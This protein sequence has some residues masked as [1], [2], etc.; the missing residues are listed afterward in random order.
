MKKKISKAR[1]REQ[2]RLAVVSI[3]LALIVWMI[4]KAGE[5][6]EAKLTIPIEVA[7]PSPQVQV[8]VIP[9]AIPVVVRYG[10]DASPYISSENFKFVVDAST[11]KDNL[12]VSWKTMTMSLSDKNWVANI[13]SAHVDLVKIGLQSSTVEV[14]MR[15]DAVPAIIKPEIVGQDRLPAGYQLVSPVKTT[16]R[17]V[18][19]IGDEDKLQK[20]SID[21]MTSRAVLKTA[22][23]SVA[24]KTESSF[25]SVELLLPPGVSVVQ[26][27]S[28]LVEV[29]LDIQ[30]VQTVR[31]IDNV[32][33]D[34]QA[35]APDT[36]GMKYQT[37]MAS[38]R[39]FGPQSLLR[40]L[41]PESFR[42]S[43]VRPQEEVPG[44][45][46]DVPLEVHF[47]A[48][49]SDEIRSRVLIQGV[50]PNSIR[51]EYVAKSRSN[52]SSTTGTEETNP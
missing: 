11:M 51:V 15:Y 30:E 36:V 47:A 14:R 43:L 2:L 9:D 19:L 3:G 21:D 23:I 44:E 32:P 18:Y 6:R 27:N 12:G 52:S 31:S 17:E 48:A 49:I 5:T 29:T 35:V 41:S 33:L 37:R 42:I 10:R 50:E 45:T 46:R 1:L 24:G 28:N 7:S 22:P 4:A 8:Q 25:E 39:V 40:Q 38:V 16:P 20:L 34:F 13:P 26:R